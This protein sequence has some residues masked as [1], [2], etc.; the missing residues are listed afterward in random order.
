MSKEVRKFITSVAIFMVIMIIADFGIGNILRVLLENMPQ[1]QSQASRTNYALLKADADCIIVGPSR[2]SEHYDSE[3]ISN[4]LGMSVYNAGRDGHFIVYDDCVLH[5]ILDRTTPKLVIFDGGDN[6]ICR[7]GHITVNSLKPYY[8]QF[9]YVTKR[10]DENN[11]MYFKYQMIS[12]L[13]RFNNMPIRL[14]EGYLKPK[15]TFNGYC[16]RGDASINDKPIE[17]IKFEKSI[18]P[19][20]DVQGEIAFDDMI[21]ICQQKNIDFFVVRSPYFVDVYSDNPIVETKIKNYNKAHFIDNYALVEFTS[22]PELFSDHGHLN[23]KGAKEFS[24][25]VAN[26]IK[27][28]LED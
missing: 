23:D 25:L 13:Y 15:D 1:T 2:A 28:I 11:Q 24:K 6:L 16:S 10:L 14:L 18:N 17:H 26:Q 8:G 27:T 22:R 4:I 5:T 20:P 19:E 21:N 12:K 9:D 3:I 7:P